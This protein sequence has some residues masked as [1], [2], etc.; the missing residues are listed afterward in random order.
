[1]STEQEM[2]ADILKMGTEEFGKRAHHSAAALA[3]VL[4]VHPSVRVVVVLIAQEDPQSDKD[5]VMTMVT[6]SNAHIEDV[7]E[8]LREAA[9]K[10]VTHDSTVN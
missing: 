7:A 1:M 9:V 10:L 3:D 4:A 6:R 2:M 8:L 5:G